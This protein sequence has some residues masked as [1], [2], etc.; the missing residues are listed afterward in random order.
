MKAQIGVKL[1]LSSVTNEKIE[2]SSIKTAQFMIKSY[3]AFLNDMKTEDDYDKGYEN[4]KQ[5]LLEKLKD[6]NGLKIYQEGYR[7][8]YRRGYENSR[9]NILNKKK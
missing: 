5:D 3:M 9:K 1:K 6:E 2:S 7:L 8:G 4:G